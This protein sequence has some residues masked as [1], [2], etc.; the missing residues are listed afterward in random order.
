MSIDPRTYLKMLGYQVRD[1]LTGLRGVVTSVSFDVNGCVQ[2][3]VTPPVDEKGEPRPGR[4]VDWKTLSIMD[5]R[6]VV[7]QPDFV[8]VPGGRDL[9]PPR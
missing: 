9:P 5:N 2:G 7:E 1:R 6:P 8:D 4:W 3:F